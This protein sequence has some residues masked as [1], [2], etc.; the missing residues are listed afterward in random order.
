MNILNSHKEK[1]G[2]L[3]A[4]SGIVEKKNINLAEERLKKMGFSEVSYRKDIFL[5]HLDYA[6]DYKRRVLE[7]NE[8]YSSNSDIIFAVRG[9]MGAVHVLH[10]LNYKLIKESSKILVGLSDVTILLNT[11]NQKLALWSFKEVGITQLRKVITPSRISGLMSI[12][13]ICQQL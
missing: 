8:A 6:G 5:K 3:I 13:Y 9:G 11:I 12:I 10:Y 4:H 2:F 7:I 1:K